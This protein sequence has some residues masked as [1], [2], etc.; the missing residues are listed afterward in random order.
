VFDLSTKLPYNDK[1]VNFLS[2][3]SYII[4]SISIIL[5]KLRSNNYTFLSY[6]NSFIYDSWL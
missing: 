4:L 2:G 3:Y 1:T 5:L 6:P